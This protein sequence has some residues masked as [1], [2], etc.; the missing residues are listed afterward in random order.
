MKLIINWIPDD[1]CDC[2]IEDLI[3]NI[4]EYAEVI[5]N[6]I[7]IDSLTDFKFYNYLETEKGGKKMNMM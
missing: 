4:H 7:N 5:S 3:V 6:P 1:H 2:L